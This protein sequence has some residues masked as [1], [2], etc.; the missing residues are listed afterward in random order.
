MIRESNIDWGLKTFKTLDCWFFDKE[1]FNF[2]SSTWQQMEIQGWGAYVLKEKLKELKSRLKEWNIPHFG[3]VH[4]SHKR[5]VKSMNDLDKKEEA[6]D[7]T[8]NELALRIRLQEDFWRGKRNP[9]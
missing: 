1:F 3:N 9:S 8:K 2:V 6:M 7:L 5:I 4:D